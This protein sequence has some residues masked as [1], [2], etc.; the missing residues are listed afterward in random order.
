MVLVALRQEV[1]ELR[2]KTGDIEKE[3]EQRKRAAEEWSATVATLEQELKELKVHATVVTVSRA[4]A[5]VHTAQDTRTEY[6]A[7]TPTC[8]HAH[9]Y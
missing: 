5:Y 8:T 7:H 1:D 2:R 6:D 9:K 3:V 4:R